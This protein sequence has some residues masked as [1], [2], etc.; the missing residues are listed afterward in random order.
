MTMKLT[1]SS[2][3]SRCEFNHPFAQP[4]GCVINPLFWQKPQGQCPDFQRLTSQ[5][6]QKNQ[7]LWVSLAAALLLHG[8]RSALASM[9]CLWSLEILLRLVLNMSYLC[10]RPDLSIGA[11]W[12]LAFAIFF[13]LIT[14]LIRRLE[15][16]SHQFGITPIQKRSSPPRAN[17]RLRCK[18]LSEN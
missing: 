14:R 16:S 8:V 11:L 18:S 12:L 10:M 2:S 17:S 5:Q 15:Y 1:S 6:R 4:M 9:A 3:C 7:R 13:P